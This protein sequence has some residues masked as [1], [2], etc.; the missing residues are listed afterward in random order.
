MGFPCGNIPMACVDRD[1]VT[2]DHRIAENNLWCLTSH[3]DYGIFG[4]D[5]IH[6]ME[7]SQLPDG[8]KSHH[9]TGDGFVCPWGLA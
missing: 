1:H 9:A 3:R 7:I 2:V 6:G 4:R 8:K 5:K